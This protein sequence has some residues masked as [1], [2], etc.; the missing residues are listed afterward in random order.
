MYTLSFFKK[1]PVR[2]LLGERRVWKGRGTKRMCVSKEDH[3][4]YIPVLETLQSLL[5]NEAILSEV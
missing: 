4:F 3:V 5:R 1:E 2:V